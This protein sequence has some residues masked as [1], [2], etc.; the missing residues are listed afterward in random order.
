MVSTNDRSKT[1]S[2]PHILTTKYKHAKDLSFKKMWGSNKRVNTE[3]WIHLRFYLF[4]FQ[5]HFL[6]NYSLLHVLNVVLR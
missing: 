5:L 4:E 2:S 3:R 6:I 1:F